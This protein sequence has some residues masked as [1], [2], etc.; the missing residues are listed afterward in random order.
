MS[1]AGD[2]VVQAGGE[3]VLD[4]FPECRIRIDSL[5]IRIYNSAVWT[6]NDDLRVSMSHAGDGVEQVGGQ[7]V[8]DSLQSAHYLFSEIVVKISK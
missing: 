2:S 4:P 7:Q 5:K 6:K 8:G 1:H 3:K